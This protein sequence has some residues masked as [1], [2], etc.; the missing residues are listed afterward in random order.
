MQYIR[1]MENANACAIIKHAFPLKLCKHN[2]LATHSKSNLW[3]SSQVKGVIIE[4]FLTLLL[5]SGKFSHVRNFV[6]SPLRVAEEI[7]VVLIF[8]APTRT[9]R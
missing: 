7:F 6:E 2:L 4:R 5:Y 3:Y 8:A 9:G 1:Y